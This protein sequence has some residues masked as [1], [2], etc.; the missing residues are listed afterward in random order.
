M[1]RGRP[2]LP[3]GEAKAEV[4]TLR[5][6]PDE[7]KAIENTASKSG[8]SVSDYV[9]GRIFRIEPSVLVHNG[10]RVEVTN[11]TEENWRFI[12]RYARAMQHPRK[13]GQG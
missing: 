1:K 9:R 13:E 11:G 8:L 7:M 6:S 5:L 3:K 10:N 4:L 2:K 12:E